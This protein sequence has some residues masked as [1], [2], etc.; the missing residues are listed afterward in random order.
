M[1]GS[2]WHVDS[3]WVGDGWQVELKLLPAVR[4]CQCCGGGQNVSCSW[5]VM[6]WIGSSSM[7]RMTPS[8]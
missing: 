7:P 6:I 4:P 2:G 5:A 1:T 8:S 3:K